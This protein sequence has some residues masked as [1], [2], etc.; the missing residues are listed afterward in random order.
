MGCLSSAS[1]QIETCFKTVVK[2]AACKQNVAFLGEPPKKD[3]A[4]KK[5]GFMDFTSL[6]HYN[7]YSNSQHEG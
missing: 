6:G 3:K 1:V 7:H 5:E 2:R 4:A